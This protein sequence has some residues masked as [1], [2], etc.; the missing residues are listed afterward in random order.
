ME[1]TIISYA[2][3]DVHDVQG[4]SGETQT[5]IN[6]NQHKQTFIYT[7]THGKKKKKKK[8]K[9]KIDPAKTVVAGPR[10]VLEFSCPI[11]VFRFFVL[12]FL[13]YLR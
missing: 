5:Q 11:S 9:K 7:H 10:L 2:P 8:K 6:P 12:F 1:A 4:W 13:S 3:D